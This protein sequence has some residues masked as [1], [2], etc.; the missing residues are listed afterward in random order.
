MKQKAR[1]TTWER[2]T[3]NMLRVFFLS[4]IVVFREQSFRQSE[5]IFLLFGR[6]F[7]F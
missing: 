6:V 1:T 2:N 3:E 4:F 5:T 7:C